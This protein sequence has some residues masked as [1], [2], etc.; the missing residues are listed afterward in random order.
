[1][2]ANVAV[3]LLCDLLSATPLKSAPIL[4][5]KNIAVPALNSAAT[6]FLFYNNFATESSRY[7]SG[8]ASNTKKIKSPSIPLCKGGSEAGDLSTK[9]SRADTEVN[10]YGERYTTCPLAFDFISTLITHYSSLVTRFLINFAGTEVNASTGSHNYVPASILR[11]DRKF[12]STGSVKQNG[13]P[14]IFRQTAHQIISGRMQNIPLRGALFVSRPAFTIFGESTP[15]AC[16]YNNF[17]ADTEV[18][19]YGEK[20]RLS[21]PSN[22]PLRCCIGVPL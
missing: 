1:M 21:A 20:K 15:R 14:K 3:A 10:L 2:S 4:F 19:L 6:V 18:Y 8:Q 11:A 22:T 17:G 9:I 13:L 5:P 12:T 7:S 16:G